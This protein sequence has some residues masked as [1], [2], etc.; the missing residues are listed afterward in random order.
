MPRAASVAPPSEHAVRV[1][2]AEP[3]HPS[4]EP[5]ELPQIVRVRRVGAGGR[6][7]Q[8]RRERG[9]DPRERRGEPGVRIRVVRRKGTQRGRRLG[10][11]VVDADR[12]CVRSRSE[13]P[14]PRLQPLDPVPFELE[15]A[16]HL[17]KQRPRAVQHRGAMISGV[18]LLG[19]GAPAHD[20][21]RLEHQRLHAS[22]R[23]HGRGDQA[24]VPRSDDDD[25]VRRAHHF[26]SA[27][28]RAAALRPGAP[29][30]PPPGCVADPHM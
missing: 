26:C 15:L 6:H 25:V 20:G 5:H 17:R 1:A 2:L 14:H 8:Q 18:D 21:P 4:P 11:V 10:R 3:P 29:M 30:I 7:R 19:H 9:A 16:R 23:Q 27:R 13:H 12:A 22:A 28:M 24:V